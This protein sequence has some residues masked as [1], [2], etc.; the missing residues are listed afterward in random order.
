VSIKV[1]LLSHCDYANVGYHLAMALCEMGIE[2]KAYAESVHPFQYPQ[3]AEICKDDRLQ[4]IISGAQILQFMHRYFNGLYVDF[5]HQGIV[6]FHGANE[7]RRNS[8]RFNRRYNPVVDVTLI[9]TRDL[10][11][12]GAKNKVW[13]MPA[14]DT[15]Y[16][17]PQFNANQILQIAHFPSSTRSKGTKDIVKAVRSLQPQQC[18]FNFNYS[19]SA[20]TWSKNI[21]RIR[22][23]D[24]Y[25]DACL[26]FLRGKRYGEWGV[27]ALEACALGKIVITH[28]QSAELYE[29]EWGVKW[30]LQIANSSIEIKDRIKFIL[31]LSDAER[32]KLRQQSRCW[33]EQYH[34]Y[35]PTAL[36]W[37]EKVYEP[38]VRKKEFNEIH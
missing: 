6:V 10:F 8:C 26:P 7:Y 17:Q 15:T 36:R 24:I 18:R 28:S 27:A 35:R 32:Q 23:C 34:S 12:L 21:E 33:I 37:I 20:V 19:T 29:K 5:A 25:V 31:D 30:P 11:D 14:I 4:E 2:A 9:Q 22:Q 13:F 38:I 1:V 3:Q 16:L